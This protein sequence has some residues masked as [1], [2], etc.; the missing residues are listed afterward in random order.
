MVYQHSAAEKVVPVETAL[1]FAKRFTPVIP[2]IVVHTVGLPPRD[3]KGN[4][5]GK[6]PARW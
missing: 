2:I 5:L 3:P 1:N 4:R 6:R